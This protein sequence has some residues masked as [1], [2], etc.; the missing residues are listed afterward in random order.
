MNGHDK[1]ICVAIGGLVVI[2][3]FALYC[4]I[5][6]TVLMTTT[7]AISGLAGYSVA[8]SKTATG[9]I[10]QLAQDDS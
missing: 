5:D 8:K 10:K 2:E 4:G 7:A 9:L 3:C 1:V 6:G